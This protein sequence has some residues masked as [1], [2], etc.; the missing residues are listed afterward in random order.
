MEI[1]DRVF[2]SLVSLL[3]LNCIKDSGNFKAFLTQIYTVSKYG[4]A[5]A[6]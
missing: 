2:Y 5:E 1:L 4:K 6:S 3:F